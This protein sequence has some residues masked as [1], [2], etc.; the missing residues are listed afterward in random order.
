VT[1][2]ARPSPSSRRP[3][4]GNDQNAPFR[5]AWHLYISNT[6]DGGK[7]WTTA[8]V[9]PKKAIHRGCVH[10]LGLAPGSQR[11]DSCSY[12]KHAR[13]QRHHARPVRPG[14]G[15]LHRRLLR[16]CASGKKPTPENTRISNVSVAH[17]IG[18]KTL[19]A[20]YDKLFAQALGAAGPG[21]GRTFRTPEAAMRYLASAWNRKDM[22][23]GSST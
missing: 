17:Q 23:R 4:I 10:M 7:T 21:R 5:G 6:Y 13:L 8:D 14:R 12:R 2:T 9:T 1:T 22:T 3:G 16:D 18:G 19:Y 15:R 20:K 11:T